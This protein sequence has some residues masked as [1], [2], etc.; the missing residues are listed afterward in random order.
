MGGVGCW[1]GLGRRQRLVEL[2][3][4]AVVGDLVL[5]PRHL[6]DL[7]RLA[8]HLA[9][10]I[11]V[12]PPAQELVLVD[13]DARPELHPPVRELVEDA[14]LLCKP[15]RVVKG[16]LPDHRANAKDAGPHG[17]ARQV[18]AGRA[19]E[20]PVLVLN[21]EVGVVP[22][23][24]H[25]LRQSNVAV[26]H[27]RNGRAAV[28]LRLGKSVP[29]GELQVSHMCLLAIAYTAGMANGQRQVYPRRAGWS[30]QEADPSEGPASWQ[31]LSSRLGGH[32]GLGLAQLA[33]L[34]E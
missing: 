31:F 7:E 2:P 12:E 34:L 21:D 4:L 15:Q 11:E 24:L 9:P 25:Q 22:K 10:R 28:H 32:C 26:I 18:D 3:V 23:L 1:K 6:D 17:H 13:A 20:L 8:A 30:T 5:R 16:K 14:H 19:D 29:Q 27:L 33:L